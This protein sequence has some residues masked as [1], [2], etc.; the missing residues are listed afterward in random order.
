[1]VKQSLSSLVVMSNYGKT[2]YY[3]ITDVRFDDLETLVFE[4][5]Q[6]RLVD[7]YK[8]KYSLTIRNMK[9]PLL[10]AEG[11][12]KNDKTTLLVPELM[13]MT[14]IPDDFDEMRRKK[15]SE[16]TIRPPG[17]KHQEISGL[18]NKLKRV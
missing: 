2:N 17:E 7:Y 15:I 5:S 11:K 6:T 3:T 4:D 1:M 10:V 18:M 12:R 9:Q 8:E 14:G 16:F 13:L